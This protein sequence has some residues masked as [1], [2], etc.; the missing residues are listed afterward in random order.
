MEPPAPPVRIEAQSL[1]GSVAATTVAEGAVELRRGPLLLRADRLTYRRADETTQ[2]EGQVLLSQDGNVFRGPSLTVRMPDMEGVFVRPE[3]DFARTKAGG[4][5][6]RIDF[7]GSNRFQARNPLYT[8]CPRDGSG[9]PDWFITA[10]HLSVDIE[11]NEAIAEGAVL[12]FLGVPV[13]ALPWMSFPA[14]RERKSGWLTPNLRI[15]NRSGVELGV[16]WYWN[17]APDKDAT[18]TPRHVSKRGYG[19]EGEFRYLG[20]AYAGQVDA[21]FTPNDALAGRSR[22]ALRLNHAVSGAAAG[23]GESARLE[24]QAIRASDNDWWKDHRRDILGL[25]PRLLPAQISWQRSLSLADLQGL[26]Y[27]R[28]Q[29]WQPLQSADDPFAPPYQ[30][31]FQ[32]GLRAAAPVGGATEWA[33]ELEF[34]RFSLPDAAA[35]R[36]TGLRLHWLG[37]AAWPRRGPAGWLVPRLSVNAAAYEFDQALSDGRQRFS[38]AIPTLSVDAGWTLEREWSLTGRPLRQ[39]LEPR[40]VYVYT[41][42]RNQPAE[43]AFDSAGR[44]FNFDSIFSTG[45]FSGVDRVSD[46]NHLNAGAVTRLIDAK[47]GD[48]LLRLALVQR[49]LFADQRITPELV[50]FTGRFSDL[51][52]LGATRVFAPWSFEGAM[53]WNADLGQTVRSVVSARYAPSGD[54]SLGVTQ[55]FTQGQASQWELSWQWPLSRWGASSHTNETGSLGCRRLWSTLGAL[56]YSARDSQLVSSKVGVKVDAGCWSGLVTAERVT[57]GPNESLTRFSF[58]LQLVGLGGAGAGF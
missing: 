6:E 49:F 41:P 32:W 27:A 55:R 45:D 35:T 16:P 18:I 36:P 10:R 14:T 20:A 12:R 40:L 1:S 39:T 58:Q 11:A 9:D 43:I 22:H 15:D 47:R 33:T 38:R 19:V 25:T 28:T 13:L 34:N 56:N 37:E 29:R 21:D 42:W 5:A 24:L 46:A 2:A 23:G 31:A 7:Q 44:D 3:F 50:P 53:R 17:I 48:E 30:R 26:T 4:R 51:Y 52:L 54:R 57:A 8:G